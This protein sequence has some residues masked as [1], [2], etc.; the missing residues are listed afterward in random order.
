MIKWK[1]QKFPIGVCESSLG[2][3]QAVIWLSTAVYY[4]SGIQ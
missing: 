3:E 2:S 4:K 1:Y